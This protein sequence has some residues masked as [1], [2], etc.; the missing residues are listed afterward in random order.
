RRVRRSGGH[1]TLIATTSSHSTGSQAGGAPFLSAGPI[2]WICSVTWLSG[3]GVGTCG[4]GTA[5]PESAMLDSS[6]FASGC[7]AAGGSCDSNQLL[8]SRPPSLA[9]AAPPFEG[10]TSIPDFPP[11][12]PPRL[13]RPSSA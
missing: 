13:A 4:C 12:A 8:V 9:G 10:P 11:S 5:G 7:S 6:I 3:G 2:S 1:Q